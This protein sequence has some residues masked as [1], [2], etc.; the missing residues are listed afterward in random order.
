MEVIL[1]SLCRMLFPTL[2]WLRSV[3]EISN[4]CRFHIPFW[5]KWEL[6][7]TFDTKMIRWPHFSRVKRY[8]FVLKCYQDCRKISKK[9][10][11]LCPFLHQKY[12]ISNVINL[13]LSNQDRHFYV[14][15]GV[16][17]LYNFNQ[18]GPQFD[19]IWKSC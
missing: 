8:S 13:L 6:G 7:K 16:S 17:G 19:M 2:I 11:Q 12:F 10:C 15:E 1:S 5:V 9:K 18:H 14:V 4:S 3:Y